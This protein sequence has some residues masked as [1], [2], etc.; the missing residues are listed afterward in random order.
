MVVVVVVVVGIHFTEVVRSKPCTPA[1]GGKMPHTPCPCF[2]G[3]CLYPIPRLNSCFNIL[4]NHIFCPIRVSPHEFFF[5]V[6][7]HKIPPLW[8]TRFLGGGG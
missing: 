4:C 8:K 5:Q 6:E 7:S 1:C 2:L 3:L